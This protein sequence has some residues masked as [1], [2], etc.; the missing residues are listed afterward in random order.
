MLSLSTLSALRASPLAGMSISAI[1]GGEAE[2]DGE[3]GIG[4]NVE[5]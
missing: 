4:V 5:V 3:V 2:H 1:A